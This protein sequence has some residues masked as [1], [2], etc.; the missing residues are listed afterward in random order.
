MSQKEIT[1]PS[2]KIPFQSLVD[3]KIDVISGMSLTAASE[4]HGIRPAVLKDRLER[5][6]AVLESNIPSLSVDRHII[7]DALSEKMKPIKEELSLKSLDIVREADK[8]VLERL[9]ENP[10]EIS[11]KD[12]LRASAEHSSRLA[13][14]T[15]MEEDPNAGIPGDEALRNRNINIFVQNIVNGHKEK[16]EKEREHV[17]DTTPTPVYEDGPPIIPEIIEE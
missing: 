4:K 7:T 10:D 2:K 16:L 1:T 9:K 17:N 14:I 8:I 13:R 12:V 3:A 15:G 5:V 11:T 6:D